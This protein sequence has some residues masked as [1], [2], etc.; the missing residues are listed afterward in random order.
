MLDHLE[1]ELTAE[2]LKKLLVKE[3]NSYFKNP[4]AKLQ[5]LMKDYFQDLINE[6]CSD[7]IMNSLGAVFKKEGITKVNIEDVMIVLSNEM[8]INLASESDQHNGSSIFDVSDSFE[9]NEEEKEPQKSNKS[10]KRN[11]LGPKNPNQSSFA[12]PRLSDMGQ[13]KGKNALSNDSKKLKYKSKR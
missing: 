7:H 5:Q 13:E 11:S 3:Q 8:A 2:F 9:S 12:S 4:H 1:E 6:V 10:S